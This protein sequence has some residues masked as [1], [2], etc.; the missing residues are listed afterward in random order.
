[1]DILLIFDVIAVVCLL[2]RGVEIYNYIAILII[3]T[4]YKNEMTIVDLALKM[5]L[6]LHFFVIDILYE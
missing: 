2:I 3:G 5:L 1:M 4:K 6:I